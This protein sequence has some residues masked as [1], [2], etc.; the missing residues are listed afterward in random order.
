MKKVK[1]ET[2]VV[3]GENTQTNEKFI[4]SEIKTTF[5]EI[6]PICKALNDHYI[7]F[8]FENVTKKYFIENKENYQNV[9][10]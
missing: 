4:H 3:I 5:G 10:K 9:R 1:K 7:K 6:G 2:F 8:Y